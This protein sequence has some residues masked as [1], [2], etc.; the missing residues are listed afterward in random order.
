MPASEAMSLPQRIK[1]RISR[2]G[3]G[4][5]FT[6]ADFLDLG[7]THAVG[8]ALLRL[9]RA[10]EIR[11]LSRGL[12]DFPKHHSRLG[13]LS[14]SADAIAQAMARRDGI[15]LNPSEAEAANR[16]RLSEQVPAKIVYQT[17]GPA[18]T[19]KVGNRTIQFRRRS[20]RRMATA[21][22]VS[23]LVFAAL[24]DLGKAHVTKQRVAHL[25]ELLRP[26]DRR[27]LL[28]D[29]P[30]APAWMHPFVRYI[31]EGDSRS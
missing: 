5:V 26:A 25:R 13:I 14:P 23:G 20:P 17:D 16:L 9:Q 19:V 15:R 29:L 11:R 18:R 12:Y 30:R 4:A 1:A 3:S 21:G 24:K 2:W 28:A 8:M 7:S 22:S 27:Q 6:R 10:G 31:A